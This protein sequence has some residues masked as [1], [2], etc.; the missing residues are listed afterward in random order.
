[1]TPKVVIDSIPVRWSLPGKYVRPA[2]ET[3]AGIAGPVKS[4]ADIAKN[5]PP[6]Q[7]RKCPIKPSFLLK[8]GF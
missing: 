6:A 7:R 4:C 1:M 2:Q 5:N 3:K 8:P